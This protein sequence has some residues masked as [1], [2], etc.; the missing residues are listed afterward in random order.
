MGV[1]TLSLEI[2][3]DHAELSAAESAVASLI[4]SAQMEFHA[5]LQ[6]LAERAAFLTTAT[7]VAI[8]LEDEG[9]FVYRVATGNSH[10]EPEAWVNTSDPQMA[11]CIEA[12]AAERGTGHGTSRLLVPIIQDEKVA[13]IFE[14]SGNYE[15]SDA[16][17][18]EMVR[19]AGLAGVALE[20]R[21]AAERADARFWEGLQDSLAPVWH[22]P[23][24]RKPQERNDSTLPVKPAMPEVH[25]CR[26][27]GF[28]VSPGRKLCVDC[29]L[30]PDAALVATPDLFS[31][32]DPST[33]IGEHGYTIAS[34]LVSLLAAAIAYWLRR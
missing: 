12:A 7:G 1:E 5:S 11:R 33:W 31:H 19:L 18:D 25:L 32:Q 16:D 27:C 22:A 30:K 2:A 29:E 4:T 6:L 15:F 20:H 24:E 13:G 17:L 14:L 34:I 23:Q 21:Q 28:P 9:Q 3:A 8:A 10:A 26:G